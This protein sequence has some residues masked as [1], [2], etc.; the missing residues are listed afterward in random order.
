MDTSMPNSIVSTATAKA[1]KPSQDALHL[2]VPNK[3]LHLPAAPAAPLVSALPQP[4]KVE[5][6]A[7]SGSLGTQL[8][9]FA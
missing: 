8:N 1:R 7:T 4:P 3:P 9:T 5:A 6:L 2:R